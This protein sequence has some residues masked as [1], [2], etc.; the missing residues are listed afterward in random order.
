MPFHIVKKME[1]AQKLFPLIFHFNSV[2][3]GV[4][5]SDQSGQTPGNPDRNFEKKT[6]AESHQAKGKYKGKK[7]K[8]SALPGVD[9]NGRRKEESGKKERTTPGNVSSQP[10][11]D[12]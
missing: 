3:K 1:L 10:V 4:A 11:A 6:A 2:A 9:P 12:S 7:I 8:N 5:G